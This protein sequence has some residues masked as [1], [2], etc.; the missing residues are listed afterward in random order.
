M[1]RQAEP[2]SLSGGAQLALFAGERERVGRRKRYV[3]RHTPGELAAFDR[4]NATILAIRPDWLAEGERL[5]PGECGKVIRGKARH[6]GRRWCGAVRR[7]WGSSFRQVITATLDAY[8]R[9]HGDEAKV[10]QGVIT[11]T[12]QS[13]WWDRPRCSHAPEVECSGPRGCRVLPEVEAEQRESWPARKRDALNS[14]RTRAIRILER[15][16][17]P[18]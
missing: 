12:A 4:T 5:C 17:L 1:G 8:C 16:G 13:W 11:C 14:A 9:L 7:Q 10:L 18:G 3:H 15:A 6:C 2:S